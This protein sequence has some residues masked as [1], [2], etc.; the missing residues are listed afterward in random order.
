MFDSHT[1]FQQLDHQAFSFQPSRYEIWEKGQMTSQGTTIAPVRATVGYANRHVITR[2]QFD[3][4]SLAYLIAN[5]LTFDKLIT[6]TDRLQLVTIPAVT[7]GDNMAISMFKMIIGSTRAE[8]HFEANEPYCCNLFTVNGVISKVSF[9]FSSPEKL[10]ELYADATTSNHELDFEFRSEDHLRFQ[11]NSLVSGPHGGAPRM[12]TVKP[13]DLDSWLVTIYSLQ[14]VHPVWQNNVQMAPKR[15]KIISESDN[16]VTLRGF[17]TD[18]YGASFADYGMTIF[19]GA[20]GAVTKCV[21]HMHDRGVDIAY[22]KRAS[23]M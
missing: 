14:G 3:D 1:A 11:N 9:S 22:F 19:Y 2:I 23:D 21:L 13:K 4:I 16:R 18:A 17:G 15:M 20:G 6:G 12:I 8:K 7:N 10:L 5:D